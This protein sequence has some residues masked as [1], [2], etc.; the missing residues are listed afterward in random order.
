LRG[1]P[2]E[3][4][5]YEGRR[6]L[7]SGINLTHLYRGQIPFIWFMDRELGFVHKFLRGVAEP[8]SFPD[9]VHGFARE[10]PWL[11]VV[12]T[13]AIG[14]HCQ[15]LLTMDYVLAGADAFMT[16]PARKE[17]I[18]PG[19]SNLRLPRFV[20]DR[21]ARQLI[22]YE[23]RLE[24]DSPEGRLICD[25]VVSPGEMDSAIDRVVHGLTSSGQSAWWATGAPSGS[26]RSPS[27]PSGA[28]A[29]STRASRPS[30]ISARP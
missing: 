6:I 17:G 8:D 27:T 30:V 28:T 22:Q 7:G 16:L 11:A 29:P 13:F 19:A 15:I 25:E 9:D 21:L 23:R 18:I 5:K 2:V 20:G 10:K 3:H 12:D 1:G 26:I 24:A 4:P 14:G